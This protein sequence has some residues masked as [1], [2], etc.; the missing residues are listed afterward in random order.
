MKAPKDE[1]SSV[2]L[3]LLAFGLLSALILTL[4]LSSRLSLPPLV[5]RSLTDEEVR[6]VIS[7]NS[8]LTEYVLLSPNAT[9]PREEP[10]TKITVH[11]MAGD[12]TLEELGEAFAQRD[13]RA[14]AN[15][16]IDSEGRVALYVEESDRAWTSSSADN[17][18]RAVT[19]EVANDQVGGEWHVSD[20]AYEA[21]LDLCTDICRRNEIQ[22]LR[23]TGDASGTLTLHSMFYSETDCPGPYLKSRMGEIAAEVDGRLH[24]E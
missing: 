1:F 9:F 2:R 17:D 15:Y 21:L 11:H 8:P 14:S 4:C 19:I 18:H 10:I 7:R 24:R 5:G 22:E 6:T 16:A 3:L 23:Y 13:R 12:L 20:A